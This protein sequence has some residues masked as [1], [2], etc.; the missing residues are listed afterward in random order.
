MGQM[1]SGLVNSLQNEEEKQKLADDAPNMMMEVGKRQVEA[2]KLKITNGNVDTKH[3]PIGQILYDDWQVR[4]SISKNPDDIGAIIKDSYSAFAKGDMADGIGAVV[5]SG[6]G[7]LLGSFEG[8]VAVV[9][10]SVDPKTVTDSSI[11][12]LVQNQFGTLG[13]DKEDEILKI[14]LD[15]KKAALSGPAV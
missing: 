13:K 10:S 5:N 7:L 3:I 8:T 1:I 14:L 11:R 4:C 12:V 15:A 6:M 9:I 2:F